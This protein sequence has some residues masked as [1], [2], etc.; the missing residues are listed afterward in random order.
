VWVLSPWAPEHEMVERCLVPP[1]AVPDTLFWQE[2]AII[3]RLL[4]QA[5]RVEASSN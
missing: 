2:T 5:L 1:A 3:S 4:E